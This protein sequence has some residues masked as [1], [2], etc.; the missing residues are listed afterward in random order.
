[1]FYIRADGNEKIGMGHVMRCLSIAEALR[2]QEEKVLFVTADDKASGAIEDRGF[3]VEILFT[4]YDDMEAELPKWD[5]V[6][7]GEKAER[8]RPGQPFLGGNPKILV[9]SYFITHHYLESLRSFAVVILMDDEKKAVYPCDALVNYN[10]YGKTSFYER[11]YPAETQLFLG[12]EYMPL[13]KQFQGVEYTV[14]N[15]AG[16]V[17]FTTGGGDSCH[18]ALSMA[19]SLLEKEKSGQENHKQESL[20]ET[21]WHFVCGPYCTDTEELEEIAGRS[22]L[23]KIH[24]NVTDMGDLMKRCDIAVSAA[25]STLYELCCVGV[26]TVGF[27]F[28]E[29]QRRNMEAFDEL[30]PVINAGNFL[31]SPEKVIEN[32]QENVDMLCHSEKLRKT[33]S[34]AMRG[35]VD[36][37]GAK[38][39]AKALRDL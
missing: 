8:L 10:I 36:G 14:R 5:L 3:P 1:M 27:Y 32:I 33:A 20:P 17:L 19:R 29:N 4:G 30:T 28:A 26:P 6:L 13:R 22:N 38:R 24:R 31:T 16:H 25:G 11:D 9:D 34:D 21:I 12:C 18:I 15:K 2:A 7:S 37:E 23:I 35:I 39:L